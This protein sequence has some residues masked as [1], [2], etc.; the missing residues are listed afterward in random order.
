MK[1]YTGD[2]TNQIAFPL[3]GIGTG[4]ISVSGIGILVDPEIN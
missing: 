2:Y 3:G 1:K 4:S